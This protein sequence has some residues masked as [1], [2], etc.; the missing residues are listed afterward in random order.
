MSS[1]LE[2][3]EAF[4]QNRGAGQSPEQEAALVAAASAFD[5]VLAT[6][7]LTPEQL[8]VLVSAVRCP[9][10]LVWPSAAGYLAQLSGRWPEVNAAIQ[11]L[12]RS[13]K[14]PMRFRALFCLK[15]DTPTEVADPL[16]R[17]GLVDKSTQVR[18]KAAERIER[19]ERRHLLPELASAL[20]AET[21][22]AARRVM[23]VS[24]HLLRDGYLLEPWSDDH[25]SLT[26]RAH[27]SHTVRIVSMQMIADRGID[28]LVLEH[29]Q[30]ADR[31]T[32]RDG[33]SDS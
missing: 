4:I 19:H 20:A 12:A 7:E 32:S 13:R 25:R 30:D 26:V 18:W 1:E 3:I 15:R 17:A 21:N 11:E 33:I 16:L 6:G 9:S 8:D 28:A 2:T 10:A 27:S 31:F 5:A 22:D 23:L 24:L 14:G 29:R